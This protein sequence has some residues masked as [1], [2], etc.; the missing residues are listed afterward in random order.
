MAQGNAPVFFGKLA[1]MEGRLPRR[2]LAVGVEPDPPPIK[3]LYALLH[4]KSRGFLWV[5]FLFLGVKIVALS[6]KILGNS[7]RNLFIV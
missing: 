1:F 5:V 2:P 6:L 4:R 3:L 7:C